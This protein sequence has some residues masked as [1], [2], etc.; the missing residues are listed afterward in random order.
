[1]EIFTAEVGKV[2]RKQRKQCLD[3]RIVQTLLQLDYQPTDGETNTD[4]ACGNEK[5]LQA[6]LCERKSAD[7]H[8]GHCETERDKRSSVV[9]QAFS[10]EDHNDLAR[11]SQI[12]SYCQ[13]CHGIRRRD[14]GAENK[15][16]RQG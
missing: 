15:T 10:F 3:R 6:C 11:H 2:R 12:L 8:G 9:Y 13:R 16:Y 5:K 7:H 4:A 1:M 14:D